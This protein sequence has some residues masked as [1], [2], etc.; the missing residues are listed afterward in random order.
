MNLESTN[1]IVV[2]DFNSPQLLA[3]RIFNPILAKKV[4]HTILPTCYLYKEAQKQGIQFITPDVFLNLK[5][6]PKNT[7]LISA[8]VTPFT[9]QLIS[10]GAKPTILTCQESPFIATRFYVGLKKYTGLFKHSF[11]FSGMKKWA[12][13]KTIYHQMF[14]SQTFNP[15]D[16]K[17]MPFEKKKFL[18][19][20]TSAKRGS[21]RLKKLFKNFILKFLYGRYVKE[22][23]KERFKTIDYFSYRPGFDLFGFGWEKS[24]KNLKEAQNIKKVY[25]GVVKDK[26]DVLRKYKFA[27]CFENC[28]FEGNVT[29][30]IFDALFAGSVP[31]YYGAPDINDYVSPNCFIDFR[32]FRDYDELCSFLSN[33]KEDKYNQYVENIKEYLQSD[34]FKKFIQENFAKEILNILNQE[35]KGYA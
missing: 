19:M 30:K 29:E 9:K 2:L 32:K 23:Y 5:D 22:I 24:G 26:I 21:K 14:F 7:L 20:I 25:K 6:K 3:N 35:F 33:I 16:F 12:S 17:I 31:I 8:L 27:I 4:S 28:I 10:C 15:N 34:L 1:K 13:K 11:L 18:V